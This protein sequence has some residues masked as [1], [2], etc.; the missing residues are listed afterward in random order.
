MVK[1]DS[2][3]EGQA[4][5]DPVGIRRINEFGRPQPA[6]A[7]GA[8]RLEQMALAR[9]PAHDFAVGGYFEPLGHRLLGFNAFRASHNI[10]L[11]LKRSGI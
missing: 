4:L 7:P 1:S 3:A 5:G 6:S 9:V 8:F 11:S 2:V 10:S